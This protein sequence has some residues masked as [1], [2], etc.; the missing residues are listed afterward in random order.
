[1]RPDQL[2][3]WGASKTLSSR[4][5]V[6]VYSPPAATL[7][8]MAERAF[9][10]RPHRRVIPPAAKIQPPYRSFSLEPIESAEHLV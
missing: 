10:A 1:M 3:M 4:N 9:A 2:R 8:R 6:A 5:V 7:R